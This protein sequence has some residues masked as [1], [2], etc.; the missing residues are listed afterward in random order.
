MLS[1]MLIILLVGI[2]K[3]VD[4]GAKENS[5]P[6]KQS[7]EVLIWYV[8]SMILLRAPHDVSIVSHACVLY[9]SYICTYSFEPYVL[10]KADLC[11]NASQGAAKW[12]QVYMTKKPYFFLVHTVISFINSDITVPDHKVKLLSIRCFDL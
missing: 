4:F 5:L 11:W 9:Q 12:Q 1:I 10:T 3:T 8:R 2:T 6:S 7:V